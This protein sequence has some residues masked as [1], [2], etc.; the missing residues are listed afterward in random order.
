[1]PLNTAT[2]VP[3]HGSHVPLLML[4]DK[5]NFYVI[6]DHDRARAPTR[7]DPSGQWLR[8]R[9]AR[10]LLRHVRLENAKSLVVRAMPPFLLE[11]SSSR[12]PVAVIGQGE[13]LE[14][15]IRVRIGMLLTML[16]SQQPRLTWAE[17]VPAFA[18]SAVG[19]EM[20]TR[21]DGNPV[22]FA[23]K[24]V[25][26]ENAKHLSGT[27]FG[28]Q[29]HVDNLP[30]L[31]NDLPKHKVVYVADK[32]ASPDVLLR[33]N[34]RLLCFSCKLYG[35]SH[36]VTWEVIKKEIKKA[37]PFHEV[38]PVT[39][40][41][42][43][44]SL[45]AEVKAMLKDNA[46]S[47]LVQAAT[48][49]KLSVPDGMEVLVLGEGGLASLLGEQPLRALRTLLRDRSDPASLSAEILN[50]MPQLLVLSPA[51]Q[52]PFELESFLRDEA[53]IDADGVKEY[54]PLLK[55]NKIDEEVLKLATDADLKEWGITAGGDRKRVLAAVE[56]RTG[57]KE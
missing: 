42:V 5:F 19:Q 52:R 4:V 14:W 30:A 29:L 33:L 1:V 36:K 20:V 23:P 7:T 48:D 6:P 10:C 57:K 49:A 2:R 46:L 53:K 41:I 39:L 34:K 26:H 13:P 11:Q 54:L 16:G 17:A 31:L 27:D 35:E 25:T 45:G 51:T 9:V 21:V 40:V 12:L 55:K 22:T 37:L 32:S 24:V 8:I 18:N 28:E 15:L 43:A 56:K 38:L 47:W 50:V 44:T 3:L